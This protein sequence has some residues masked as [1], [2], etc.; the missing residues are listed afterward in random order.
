M[1]NRYLALIIYF[2]LSASYA[3]SFEAEKSEIGWIGLYNK[4]MV[5]WLENQNRIETLCPRAPG[6]T[7][8][9]CRDEK[10]KPRTWTIDVREKSA[11]TSVKIGTIAIMATPGTGLTFVFH[12]SNASIAFTI[13]EMIGF[14]FPRIPFRNQDGSISASLQKHLTRKISPKQRCTT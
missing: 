8:Q 14:F 10:L 3:Y 9:Q 12:S 5:E 7:F 13:I 1:I 2:I 4:E 6:S 11:T